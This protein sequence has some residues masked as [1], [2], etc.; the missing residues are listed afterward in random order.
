MAVTGYDSYH[1]ITIPAAKMVGAST[2]TGYIALVT[3]DMLLAEVMDTGTYSAAN[4]GGDIA[5]SSDSAGTNQL[6]CHVRQFVTSATPANTKAFIWVFLGDIDPTNDVIFYIHYG[7]TGASQPAS[8]DTYGSRAVYSNKGFAIVTH[9]CQTNDVTDASFTQNGNAT[10]GTG[11]FGDDCGDYDGSGDSSQISLSGIDITGNMTLLA[12]VNIDGSGEGYDYAVGLR[13]SNGHAGIVSRT[14]ASTPRFAFIS[15]SGTGNA[16]GVGKSSD[17]AAG[18]HFIQGYQSALGSGITFR[19]DKSSA[20][21]SATSGWPSGTNNTAMMIGAYSGGD[22]DWGGLVGEVWLYEGNLGNDWGDTFYNNTSDPA[23]FASAGTAVRNSGTTLV[24]QSASHSH[25]ADALVLS[26]NHVLAIND[27]QHSHQADN[28]LLSQVHQLAIQEATHNH[29]ADNL[30]LDQEQVL[31]I[32]SAEH[33]HMADNLT[34]SFELSLTIQEATHSHTADNLALVQDHT[35]VIAEATHSH[36]ADNLVLSTNIE[37]AIQATEHGHFADNLDLN[38]NYTL[39]IQA[40]EHG[41]FADNLDL[42]QNY[43]LVIQDAQHG[44]TVDNV[45]ISGYLTIQESTHSHIA[46]NLT[47]SQ[48]NVLEIQNCFHALLGDNVTLVYGT[49]EW[50]EQP[51]DAG[52]WTVQGVNSGTW[53]EQAKNSNPWTEA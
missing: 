22:E 51:Q 9:D 23:T 50:T 17:S 53:S 41:H 38:Q 19:Q 2:L 20:G 34:I 39:V 8:T 32:Q 16:S 1:P 13:D 27:A 31:T 37:L 21:T 48:V 15:H 3:K 42:S 52:I 28:L 46:D 40:A 43:I 11:P 5:F 18:W 24:I 36:Q 12:W 6:P 45:E 14:A 44:H 30:D 33:G 10:I 26:Q 35:L 29:T 49:N 25:F 4:G 7:K 47:L